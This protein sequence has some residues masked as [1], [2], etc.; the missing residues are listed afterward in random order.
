M[1]V[2]SWTGNSC[3]SLNKSLSRAREDSEKGGKS[4]WRCWQTYDMNQQGKNFYVFIPCN[5]Y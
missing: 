1:A 3:D 2:N 4:D 5:F